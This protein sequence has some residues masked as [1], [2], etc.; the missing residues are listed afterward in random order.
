M[1]V[2]RLDRPRLDGLGAGQADR[3]E[4]QSRQP[5]EQARALRRVAAAVAGDMRDEAIFRVADWEGLDIVSGTLTVR[6]DPALAGL[7]I[8]YAVPTVDLAHEL[9]ARYDAMAGP[10]SPPWPW[11]MTGLR[12]SR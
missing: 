4:L 12:R 11:T 9:K 6:H 10:D 5:I 3:G 7:H 1:D 2:D 8:D